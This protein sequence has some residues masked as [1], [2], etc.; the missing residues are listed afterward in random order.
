MNCVICE[1]LLQKQEEID[2]DI[3]DG[4]GT[5]TVYFGFGSRHDYIGSRNISKEDFKKAS[6]LRKI[7]SC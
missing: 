4:A 5:A 2:S 1:K 6:K 3:P 7:T